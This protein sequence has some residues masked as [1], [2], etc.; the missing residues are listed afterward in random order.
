MGAG[1]R[2]AEGWRM[3][4]DGATGD[5]ATGNGATGAAG[6]AA[7]SPVGAS[8]RLPVAAGRP[9]APWTIVL[10]NQKGGTGKST[11]A[12]HLVVALL[13]AGHPVGV[14]DLDAR[15]GT[16]GR[17]IANRRDYAARHRLDLPVPPIEAVE[18]GD[19]EAGRFEV[20]YGRLAAAA[21]FIV[22][23]TPGS[24]TPL[25]RLGHTRAD[26][27]ITPINDSFVDLDLLAIVDPD[28]HDVIRPSTYAALVWEQR[29][30]RALRR[31]RPVDWIVMRNRLAA[32]DARNKREMAAILERLSRR[33]GFRTAPG[34]GERVIFR[35]LFLKGLTL[36]DFGAGGAA[37]AAGGLTMSHVAARQEVRA[38]LETVGLGTAA[39]GGAPVASDA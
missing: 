21:A 23:D 12:M 8:A 32:L 37:G 1:P 16:I 28:S 9:G 10:G 6:G 19:G 20:A 27:L 14:L 26:T 22:M 18:P 4:M 39:A 36:L 25:S 38:L 24:D 29:Q 30:Q 15:Q 11:T 17:Y 13:R 5:G 2:L 35:E 33:I 31:A 7:A 3:A 34:F